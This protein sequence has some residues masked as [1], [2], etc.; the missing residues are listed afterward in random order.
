MTRHGWWLG[1]AAGVAMLLFA[2][3]DARAAACSVNVTPVSFGPYDVFSTS[4]LTAT[5][6]V[7][8]D[9]N[10]SSVISLSKGSSSSYTWRRLTKGSDY[11]LYN[12]YRNVSMTLIWGDGT[13]GSST[14]SVSSGVNTTT[15]Y[16]QITASQDIP[17]GSYSDSIV[18]TITF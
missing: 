14:V 5:A 15:I 18:A 9:C 6:T 7:T 4:P 10:K 8:V 11:L 12:L 2:A 17:A 1:L 3:R 13:G 16:A